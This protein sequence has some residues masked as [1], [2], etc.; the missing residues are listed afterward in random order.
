MCL[1]L[2]N[3]TDIFSYLLDC[4]FNPKKCISCLCCKK[5]EEDS[6]GHVRYS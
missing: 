1:L 4:C 5:V 6:D 2:F 3:N